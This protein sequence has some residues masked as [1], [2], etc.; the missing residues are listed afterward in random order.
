MIGN[1]AAAEHRLDDLLEAKDEA[2]RDLRDQLEHMCRESERKDAIIMQM[3]QANATLV[4]RVP[5][6]E[7][8]S[9]L[10]E[11]PVTASEGEGMED[12]A[13]EF[14]E[15]VDLRSWWRRVLGV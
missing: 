5:E 13:P 12:G 4:A 3:A 14:Q 1:S 11:S 7:A 6:L 8:A 10:R 15:P 9:K 2:L